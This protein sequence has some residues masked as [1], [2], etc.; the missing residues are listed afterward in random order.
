M[1]I[2]VAIDVNEQ[3]GELRQ[4]AENY[5]KN[6]GLSSPTLTLPFH[7]SL[8]ISF[9]IPDDRFPEAV[10]D[11]REFY[12]SLKPFSITVRGIEQNGPIVWIAMQDSTE[13]AY[14]HKSLDAM[15]LEK[16]GIVQHAFDKAFLFHT[17]VLL[18]NHEEQ[19]HQ[20]FHEMKNTDIPKVLRA[21]RFIIGSSEEGHAG[22]YRVNEEID[23]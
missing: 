21:E 14:I 15:L 8:K 4:K 20:A 10:N 2:W 5:V 23:L 18:I 16:Y 22:T 12:K 11:I 19:L 7:I 1:Y 13:L 3:V 17:S 9:Q 6:H